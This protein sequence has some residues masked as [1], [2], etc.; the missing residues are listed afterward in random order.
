MLFFVRNFTC[1][2][3]NQI[4][5]FYIKVFKTKIFVKR[6][7][8][9]LKFAYIFHTRNVSTKFLSPCY[10]VYLVQIWSNENADKKSAYLILIMFHREA[11]MYENRQK[12][13]KKDYGVNPP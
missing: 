8:S 9:I 5:T 13:T 11:K 6:Y 10:A 1:L 12:Q 3:S 2:N 4:V 7:C